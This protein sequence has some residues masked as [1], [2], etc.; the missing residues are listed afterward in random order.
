M[1][2]NRSVKLLVPL[3]V[4]LLATAFVEVRAK[5]IA[6][7]LTYNINH[8]GPTKLYANG[9]VAVTR[10]WRSQGGFATFA[11]Y[12]YG[13]F[14]MRIKMVPG[15]SA[16][17]VTTAYLTT[18]TSTLKGYNTRDEIDWEFLGNVDGNGYVVHTNWF[19]RGVGHHEEQ[20][21]LWFDPSQA[22]HT[23]TIQWTK[24]KVVWF[25]D[26]IPIRYLKRA[27][28]MGF[29]TKP[30]YYH[31]AVW[32]GSDFATD[33]GKIKADFNR[34]PFTALFGPNDFSQTCRFVKSHPPACATTRQALYDTG[35]TLRQKN[36]FRQYRTKYLKYTWLSQ[37]DPKKAA[38]WS[39]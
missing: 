30:L 16:G 4:L 34:G 2:I 10:D 26:D 37:N 32:D 39:G 36:Q 33:G 12:Q 7:K 14:R 8:R 20:M 35:L 19:A 17:I 5:Q 18:D 31:G 6:T 22:F 3:V 25:V 27:N 29:P 28:K 1:A 21:Y 24:N 38:L 23:Y 15:Y 9:T 11:R 13:I